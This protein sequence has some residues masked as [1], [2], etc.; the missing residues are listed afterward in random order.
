MD[1]TLGA[2]PSVP[3][4]ASIVLLGDF[5]RAVV[6]ATSFFSAGSESIAEIREL[7]A[8][9]DLVSLLAYPQLALQLQQLN[10]ATTYIVPPGPG[11]VILDNLF[12]DA[13]CSWQ[14]L[15]VV[16]SMDCISAACL[17]LHSLTQPLNVKQLCTG[18]DDVSGTDTAAAIL[19]LTRA[20]QVPVTVGVLSVDVDVRSEGDRETGT[21]L[22]DPV[23]LQQQRSHMRHWVAQLH[24]LQHRGKDTL[25]C[26]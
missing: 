16:R 21:P 15:Q 1:R 18:V 7:R 14:Q 19:T 11:P 9:S 8:A 26:Q 25:P 17:P 12:L 4:G 6:L 22:D 23:L 10:L 20:C 13:P 2:S 5:H 3:R 24:A